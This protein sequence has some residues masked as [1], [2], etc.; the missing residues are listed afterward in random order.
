MELVAADE[1]APLIMLLVLAEMLMDEGAPE[2]APKAD[3][4]RCAPSGVV[5]TRSDAVD[6]ALDNE[7]IGA[8]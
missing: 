2:C 8:D 6:D 4:P 1:V 3:P 5:K 7:T